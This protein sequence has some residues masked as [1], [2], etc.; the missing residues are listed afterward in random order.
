[1]DFENRLRALALS[2]ALSLSAITGCNPQTVEQPTPIVTTTPNMVPPEQGKL[3]E[4]RIPLQADPMNRK[5][6]SENFTLGELEILFAQEDKPDSGTF[7]WLFRTSL[8]PNFYIPRSI[9]VMVVQ[10]PFALSLDNHGNVI[11]ASLGNPNS[12]APYGN[13]NIPSNDA[14][15]RSSKGISLSWTNR[16]AITGGFHP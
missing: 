16:S 10:M 5:R 7:N 4:A 14:L 8:S 1:M 15:V 9:L 11:I 2:G 12:P 3:N 13:H 6:F